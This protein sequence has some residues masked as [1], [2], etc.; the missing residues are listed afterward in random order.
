MVLDGEVRADDRD[1]RRAGNHAERRA[2]RARRDLAFHEAAIERD[3]NLAVARDR[4]RRVAAE[5][6]RRVAEVNRRRAVRGR[7]SRQSAGR[8]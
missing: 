7:P 4:R 3:V 1:R 6:E 5:H 2:T 8:R